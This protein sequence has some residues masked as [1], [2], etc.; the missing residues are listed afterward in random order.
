MKKLMVLGSER[1]DRMLLD[2]W[3]IISAATEKI[4]L[5]A[6][7]CL[8]LPLK[9][10]GVATPPRPESQYEHVS[11]QKIYTV[12]SGAVCQ[13]K[14]EVK[15]LKNSSA[16]QLNRKVQSLQTDILT[17]AS[18]VTMYA[19]LR[20]HVTNETENVLWSHIDS[21]VSVRKFLREVKDSRM[22]RM[23]GSTDLETL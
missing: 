1:V 17:K 10:K 12:R 8:Y 14:G 22:C 19:R 23:I 7:W 2:V 9:T 21:K 13:T 20:N 4:N 16:R 11:V 15:H 6:E 5:K 3:F 18:E